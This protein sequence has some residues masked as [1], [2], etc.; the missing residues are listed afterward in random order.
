MQGVASIATNTNVNTYL[1]LFPGEPA[2][3]DGRSVGTAV[4]NLESINESLFLK[5]KKFFLNDLE[6]NA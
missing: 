3:A 4:R 5:N 6:K 1:Q 2:K